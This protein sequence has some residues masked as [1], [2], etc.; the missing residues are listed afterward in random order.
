MSD[1]GTVYRGYKYDYGY[2][3][4]HTFTHIGKWSIDNNDK[5]TY[6]EIRV[7]QKYKNVHNT[8]NYTKEGATYMAVLFDAVTIKDNPFDTVKIKSIPINNLSIRL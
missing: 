8:D 1:D 2:V 6:Y 5:D 3:V 7:R 4:N